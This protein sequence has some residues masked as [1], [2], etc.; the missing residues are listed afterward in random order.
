M[1]QRQKSERQELEKKLKKLKGAMREATQSELDGL[2]AKHQAELA[3]FDLKVGTDKAT[4]EGKKE[5]KES[6]K[7]GK[8]ESKKEPEAPKPKKSNKELPEIR[9]RQWSGLSKKELEEEC[10]LRGIGKKGGKEDLITKLTIYHQDL[11]IAEKE[12]KKA[13]LENDD[14][15]EQDSEEEEEEEEEDEEES[16]DEDEDDDESDDDEAPEVS[17]E[18][19]EKQAKRE[20]MMQKAI[21]HL[22]TEKFPDGFPL[23]EFEDRLASINVRGF[24]PQN[25][26]YTTVEKFI[27]G[28]PSALLKYKKKSQMIL[29]P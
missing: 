25:C 3:E 29:P 7:D 8:K 23:A 18:E 6:K 15:E 26:G 28:Q 14:E 13:A 24:T 16:E 11:L 27:K 21:R 10:V 4:P 2:E 17:P 9:N 5:S 20:K 22:L 12:K 1:I 19:M